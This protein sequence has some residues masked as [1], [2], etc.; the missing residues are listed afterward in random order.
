VIALGLVLGGALGNMTDRIRLG[1]VIDFIH[2]HVGTWSFYIFKAAGSAVTASE[3]VAVVTAR[4]RSLP[5][6]MCPIDDPEAAN[7]TCTCPLI[8][9]V[10]AGATPRYGACT[11]STP[12][13]ILTGIPRMNSEV[14]QIV[15]ICRTA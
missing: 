11:M 13:I 4:A 14:G 2:F 9:S 7:I 3:R 10:S 5:A 1:Y 6:L 12:V 15:A 8:R